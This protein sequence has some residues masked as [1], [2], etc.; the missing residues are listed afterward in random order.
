MRK[1]S[2]CVL[3]TRDQALD[4]LRQQAGACPHRHPDT[5]LGY[6]N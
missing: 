4:A 6:F 3:V 5:A 1:N 2:R